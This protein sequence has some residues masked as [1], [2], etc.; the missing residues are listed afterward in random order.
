[1]E[2]KV[3]S[4]Q[5]QV[6]EITK[7]WIFA[8]MAE[9][10]PV[11]ISG[12]KCL[13]ISVADSTSGRVAILAIGNYVDKDASWI[14]LDRKSFSSMFKSMVVSKSTLENDLTIN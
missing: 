10:W 8:R 4:S 1:M 12:Q 5:L 9:K 2:L 6:T 11:M 14:V 3:H 13:M 7:D